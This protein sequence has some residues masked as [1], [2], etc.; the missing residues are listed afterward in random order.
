MYHASKRLFLESWHS[1][2]EPNAINEHI[3]IPD[4][5]KALGN[6]KWRLRGSF[7]AIICIRKSFMLKKVIVF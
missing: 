1:I 2:R 4:I 5:Y 7:K 6:P 3:Y